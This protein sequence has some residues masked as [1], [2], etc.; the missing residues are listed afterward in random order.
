MRLVGVVGK[1]IRIVD[2]VEAEKVPKLKDKFDF[3]WLDID[4]LGSKE[5]KAV[6]ETFGLPTATEGDYPI[7]VT[8]DSFDTVILNYYE[9][10]YM[11]YLFIY[12][13]KSFL[14]TIHRRPSSAVEE[15]MASLN[16][17]LVTGNLSS[18]SILYQLILGIVVV[19]DKEIRVI[20]ESF[21][22]FT[23]QLKSGDMD[24]H[25]VFF[26]HKRARS[27]SKVVSKTK[28]LILDISSTWLS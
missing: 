7:V 8:G 16:E 19:N 15:A 25:R 24:I 9:E 10:L 1:D 21:R 14:I 23:E 13:S 2:G 6:Q 22:N 20:E 5:H 18:E 28:D 17:M 4:K 3:L 27:S 12:Y 11:R 26:L